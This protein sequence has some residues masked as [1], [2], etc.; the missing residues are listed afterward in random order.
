MISSLS[1]DSKIPLPNWMRTD[2]GSA[3]YWDEVRDY[4]KKIG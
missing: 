2:M 4:L 3:E 1:A